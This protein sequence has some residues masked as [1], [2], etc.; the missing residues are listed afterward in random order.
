MMH[1]LLFLLCLVVTLIPSVKA[2]HLPFKSCDNAPCHAREF[3]NLMTSAQA[4]V[5]Q[6]FGFEYNDSIAFT[7]KAISDNKLTFLKTYAWVNEHAINFYLQKLRDNLDRLDLQVDSAYLVFWKQGELITVDPKKEFGFGSDFPI[8]KAAKKF[9]AKGKLAATKYFMDAAFVTSYNKLKIWEGF[10]AELFIEKGALTKVLFIRPPTFKK[11]GVQVFSDLQL[12]AAD[13]FTDKSISKS[14]SFSFKME[15]TPNLKA[16]DT[17]QYLQNLCSIYIENKLWMPLKGMVLKEVGA[18]QLEG[19]TGPMGYA[20][21]LF[22][23]S[24]Y[25]NKNIQKRFWATPKLADSSARSNESDESLIRP[26]VWKGCDPELD[27]ELLMGCFSKSISA[28]IGQEF[29]YPKKA[30]NKGIQGRVLVYFVIEK[31]GEIQQ[32][33]ISEGVHPL[34]DL[35]SIRVISQF[36]DLEQPAR[37]R[38]TAVR[39]SFTIPISAKLQ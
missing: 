18:P 22:L 20:I 19:D 13:H 26:P 14:G 38:G 11:K 4:E 6:Y 23:E 17:L 8:A 10:K 3:Q 37:Y 34:L 30:R 9:N 39:L 35:E 16:E 32:I 1:K 21:Y 24:E 25:A 12:F 28:A 33:S 7:I 36:P 29:K 5:F 2:G 31:N 15:I 27:D